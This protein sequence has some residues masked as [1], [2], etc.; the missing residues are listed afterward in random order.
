MKTENLTHGF[1]LTVREV[2]VN[3]RITK[4]SFSVGI[5]TPSYCLSKAHTDS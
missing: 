3:A 5:F 4:A 2:F 1:E